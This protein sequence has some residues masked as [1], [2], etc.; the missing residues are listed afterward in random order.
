MG[1]GK[2]SK[3][4]TIG[5]HYS[6]GMHMIL[7]HG[8]IDGVKQI[9]V[10]EKCAWPNVDDSTELAA[11]GEASA[12]INEPNLF[13]G[14]EKEGGV[15]GTVDFA[16]GA[17]TQ[18]ANSYLLSKLDEYVPAFRGL[19]GIILR[20]VRVGTSPYIKPWSFL[21]KRTDILQDGSAQWYQ[22]KA[23]IAGDMNPAHIIRECLTNS[24]WGLNYSESFLDSVSFELA[25][26]ILYSE[27]FGL[28]F[29]WGT[30]M[31]VEDFIL[32]VLKHIDGMLYQDIQTGKFVLR[33]ARNNYN[34]VD[35]PVCNQTH[36]QEVKDFNRETYGEIVNQIVVQFRD[37]TTDKNATATVQD[38]AVMNL[39]GG[40]TI[41]SSVKYDGITKASLAAKVAARELRQA[42]SLLAR[43]TVIGNRAMAHLKPG[44]VFKLTWPILG[45]DELVVRIATVNYGN[46]LEGSIEFQ[47]IE[48]VFASSTSLVADTP[49]SEWFDP[50]S[51][52]SDVTE[53]LLI[54]APYLSLIELLG[55]SFVN[56]SLDADAGYLGLAA[57]KPVADAIDYGAYIRDSVTSD[58][59]Y[60]GNGD[61][62]PTATIKAALNKNAADATIE[63]ENVQDLDLVAVNTYAVI[64]N[65]VVK[66]KAVDTATNQITIARGILDTAPAFHDVAARMWFVGTESFFVNREYT[67]TETPG[68][69]ILPTTG[70]G[71]LAIADATAHNS[72]AMNSRQIRPYLPGALKINTVSYPTSFTGQPTISWTHRDRTQQTA[73]LVEHGE[74]SIG[75]ETGVTYTLNIYDENNALVRTETGLT[76]TSYAY[77]E[78]NERA[79]CTL[80]PSDPLNTQ[81]RFELWSV[82]DGY[83]SWQKYDITAVRS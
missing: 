42:T 70:R 10:G 58:F 56:T 29:L 69:K 76:G 71:Q 23:D 35:L 34:L 33:L 50:I 79:D 1:S 2:G 61:F 45:L 68:V 26:D 44:D 54:E 13:G 57:L 53:Y 62:T 51:V 72:A 78:A 22:A 59:I 6:L 32:E 18:A 12:V 73:Y 75:P 39:Q 21:C 15:V 38:I 46:L 40:T 11:D 67:V 27:D 30:D 14:E 36:I 64:E 7:C 41:E 82:R 77:T 5:Y 31:A 20:C 37:E 24:Q 19:V 4:Q 52:S 25:A 16:Y 63:L 47:V 43:M 28:S 55:E 49:S 60:S 8:P 74:A 65:E 9:W 3:K 83:D 17:S 48:D 80:G 66:I 81:L